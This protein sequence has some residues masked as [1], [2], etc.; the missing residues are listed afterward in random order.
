M[1]IRDMMRRS[2]QFHAHRPAIIAGESRLTF[3]QAWARGCRM[4]NLLLSM[5][6]K[7]G[8]AVASLEDNTLEAVDFFLG[9]AIANITRVPLYARNA[10]SSHLYMMEHT[11]CKAVVVAE[12]S[13]VATLRER[14][15]NIRGG[16]N[17]SAAAGAGGAAPAVDLFHCLRSFTEMEQLGETEMWRC[18]HCQ[19]L[20][21]AYKRIELW[22]APQTRQ[23][24]TDH[25][26]SSD[27]MRRDCF[28]DNLRGVAGTSAGALFGLVMLLNLSDAVC[29]ELAAAMSDLIST[30]SYHTDL[31]LLMSSYG[32]DD[33]E[34][35]TLS[36][37]GKEMS[38]SRERVRQIE[39]EALTR[40]RDCSGIRAG[41]NLP[42]LSA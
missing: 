33:G 26:Q 38:L 16:P 22:S 31:T 39:R 5:G 28:L 17:S 20:C 11:H 34:F 6:L 27:A 2:A 35:R 25:L 24:L 42:G 19:Q 13:S 9:A 10:R 41:L 7:P 21:R 12:H 36:E 18:D 4:A 15:T 3:A 1:N 30:F 8:D 40:L 14:T 23:A 37:V 29:A 32:L